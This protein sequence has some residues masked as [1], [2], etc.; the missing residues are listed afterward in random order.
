MLLLHPVSVK[1]SVATAIGVMALALRS[2]SKGF[3]PKHTLRRVGA[4][5]F[6][7]H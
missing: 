7:V 2:T 6:I 1:A 4:C 5:S 3:V